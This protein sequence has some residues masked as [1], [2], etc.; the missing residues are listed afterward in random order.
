MLN[1]LEGNHRANNRNESQLM[2]VWAERGVGWRGQAGERCSLTECWVVI[3]KTCKL[4][5]L[6]LTAPRLNNT[7]LLTIMT[8]V[9]NT[10]KT[11]KTAHLQASTN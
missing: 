10:G 9:M 8:D 2:Q 1:T 11:K 3:G 5:F 4:T 7:T 6:S